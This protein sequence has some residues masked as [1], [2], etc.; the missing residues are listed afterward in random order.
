MLVGMDF[1]I[2]SSSFKILSSQKSALISTLNPLAVSITSLIPSYE[3]SSIVTMKPV[4]GGAAVREEESG[5][6]TAG[7]REER[8]DSRTEHCQK[9]LV[10]MD[11]FI[12]SSS[13]KLLSSQKSSLISTLN[14]LA[15]SYEITSIVTLK[16]VVIMLR[17]CLMEEEEQS[18]R[19]MVREVQQG[20][21]RRGRRVFIYLNTNNGT[22]RRCLLVWISYYQILMLYHWEAYSSITTVE[23]KPWITFKGLI[24][25]ISSLHNKSQQV[26]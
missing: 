24:R 7:S 17:R 2:V 25:A 6:G 18:G 4:V 15:V 11:F 14:P 20:V 13:F 16:P 22:G 19:R 3:I 10:G 8:A 1:F 12:V 26:L 23:W 9:M 5:R 21:E